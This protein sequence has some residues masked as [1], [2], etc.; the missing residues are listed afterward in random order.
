VAVPIRAA[1]EFRLNP[2]Y[3]R[4]GNASPDRYRLQFPDQEYAQEYAASRR[5]LPDTVTL[6]RAVVERLPAPILPPALE[7]LARRRVILDLPLRYW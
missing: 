5:Y 6:E 7:E 3:E 1:G 4:D 2:L